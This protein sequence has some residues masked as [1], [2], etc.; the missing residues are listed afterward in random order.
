[1]QVTAVGENAE[2]SQGE[3][4]V[5]AEE[6]AVKT[7]EKKE[8]TSV[9][10]EEKKEEPAVEAEEK[11]EETAVKTEEYS[12]TMQQA[13]GTCKFCRLSNPIVQILLMLD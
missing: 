12:A 3:S 8:E 6:P 2:E 9:K 4:A 5:K 13:M 10:A 11:K 7:E 1:M